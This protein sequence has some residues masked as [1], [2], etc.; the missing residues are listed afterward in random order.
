M[1]RHDS[2]YRIIWIPVNIDGDGPC[3]LHE[4]KD[5]IFEVWDHVCETHGSSKI[6][7]DMVVLCYELNKRFE[8][9]NDPNYL[10]KFDTSIVEKD[11]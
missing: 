5:V 7:H 11:G 1:I 10:R 2:P 9:G 3:E 6:L 8:E 4:A